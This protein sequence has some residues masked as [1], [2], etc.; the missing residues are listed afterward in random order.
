MY[1]SAT[2]NYLV[3]FIFCI[4]KRIFLI[5]LIKFFLGKQIS[6]LSYAARYSTPIW[7]ASANLATSGLH[8]CY[9]HKQ[10]DYLQFGVEF[11]SNFRQQE[12]VTTFGYQIEIPN[13]ATF[14][15]HCDTNW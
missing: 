1:I 7:T 12:A 10:N 2:Q 13:V 14:R 3:I 5:N 4:L 9:H 15:A 8:L 6:A 11:D